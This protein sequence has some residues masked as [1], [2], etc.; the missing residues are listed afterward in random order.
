[1]HKG[2]ATAYLFVNILLVW[3]LRASSASA[4]DA[5]DVRPVAELELMNEEELGGQ[6]VFACGSVITGRG[7]RE[8]GQPLQERLANQYLRTIGLVLRK[9]NEASYK[10]WYLDIVKASVKDNRQ[11]CYDARPPNK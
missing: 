2:G 6:A 3:G 4:F 8:L 5:L 11:A 10:T 9:K 1:M 7:V